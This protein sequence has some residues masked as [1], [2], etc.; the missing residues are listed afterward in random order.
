MEYNHKIGTTG[1]QVIRGKSN[2]RISV[3]SGSCRNFSEIDAT[4]PSRVFEGLPFFDAVQG[5]NL[6]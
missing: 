2:F 1:N 5:Y 4:Q 6:K 3:F